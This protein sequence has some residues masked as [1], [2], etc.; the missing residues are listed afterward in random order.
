MIQYTDVNNHECDYYF[1][2]SDTK[3]CGIVCLGETRTHRH[4]NLLGLIILSLLYVWLVT[5]YKLDS[6]SG[7]CDLNFS[8]ET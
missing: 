5:L 1:G 7:L 3:Y 8:H 2:S 4:K 6:C